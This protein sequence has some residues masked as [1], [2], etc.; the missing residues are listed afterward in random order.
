[1]LKD[2]IELH[3]LNKYEIKA[4]TV[5]N[6]LKGIP[7]LGR[8]L[9]LWRNIIDSQLDADRAD[10]LLRDSHHIGVTYGRFDLAR[11]LVTILVKPD[12]DTA[13]PILV[14]KKAAGMQWKA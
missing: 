5:A 9:L 4:H 7:S 14:V 1:M 8:E 3:P 13:A 12:P 6:F 2:T 10:Y 11:I